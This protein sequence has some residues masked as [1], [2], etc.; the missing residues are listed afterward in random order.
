MSETELKL[1]QSLTAESVDLIPYLPYLLQD[2]WDLGAI[3]EDV[4]ALLKRNSVL[5][6]EAKALD[7][8][9]GKG[10]VSVRLAAE[11]GCQVKGID[12]M[13]A[14]VEHAVFM[15]RQ[16]Q[17]DQLCDFVVGDIHEAV[18]SERSY[19]L[20]VLGAVGDLIGSPAVTL[21]KLEKTIRSGGCIVLDDAYGQG[22]EV[23][24]FL[25]RTEW[26]QFFEQNGLRLVD[27]IIIDSQKMKELNDRQ[28]PLIRR[29]ALELSEQHPQLA[30]LFEGYIRSQQAECE[31]LEQILEGVTMLLQ[32]VG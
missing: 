27:E 1:A 17:V 10:A 21:K 12:L 7:L 15:A 13:P 23:D 2:L 16:H 30:P 25:S 3:P 14:F 18:E 29:R 8:A 9:C 6:S 24:G 19:D 32:K 11:F 26:S 5:T 20:V 31:E 22:L 28:Q 4:I